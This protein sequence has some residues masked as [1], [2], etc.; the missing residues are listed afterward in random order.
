MFTPNALTLSSESEMR[1]GQMH[2]QAHFAAGQRPRGLSKEP[3]IT[4]I[5]SRKSHVWTLRLA[6]ASPGD[7]APRM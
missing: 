3:Q 5:Q 4:K 7:S 2:H 6:P 1:H